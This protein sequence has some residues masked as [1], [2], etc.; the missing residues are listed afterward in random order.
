MTEAKLM[1]YFESD[2]ILYSKISMFEKIFLPDIRI[3]GVFNVDN[4]Q[5]DKDSKELAPP[6]PNLLVL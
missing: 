2:A 6:D 4:R 1:K 3:Q 5:F